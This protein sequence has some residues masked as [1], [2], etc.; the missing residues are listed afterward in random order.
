[1]VATAITFTLTDKSDINYL[2]LLENLV[3]KSLKEGEVPNKSEYVRKL[4]LKE[5][6]RAG[7]L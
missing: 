6:K 1:M 2:E 5:G 3:S 4:L 7:L